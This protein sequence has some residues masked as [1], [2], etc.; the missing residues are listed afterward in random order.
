MMEVR[1]SVFLLVPWSENHSGSIPDRR[2]L[3]KSKPKVMATVTVVPF[4]TDMR[5]GGTGG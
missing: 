2:D 3:V 4:Y 1:I 5:V